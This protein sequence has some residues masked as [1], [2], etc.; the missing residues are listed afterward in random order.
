MNQT[1]PNAG[2]GRRNIR[3][4]HAHLAQHGRAMSM[5]RLESC[6]DLDDLHRR[7]RAAVARRAPGAGSWLLGVGLRIESWPEP[8]W[9]TA[10]ELDVSTG[11]CPT[12]LWSFDHHA[13]VVN[14]A[15]L[16]TLGI[17]RGTPDPDNGRIVRDAHSGHLTGLM[18]ERAAKMVWSRIPEPGKD[19]RRQQVRDALA[20]LAAHGFTEIHDLLS[21]P[22]LGPLL[23]ELDDAG[24]LPAR[25]VLYPLLPDFEAVVA[26]RMNWERDRLRLGGA[27]LFADG[28]L[29][30]R[31]AWMLSEYADPL[32]G[33]PHG[34]AMLSVAD[35][36]SAMERLW[37]EGLGLAVH[38]IGDGAVRAVLDAGEAAHIP[39]TLP[40]GLPPLRIEH[41]EIIDEADIPRFTAMGVVASVQPCHLL[42]DIEVLRR[43]LP[44]R[45]ERVLPLRDLIDSG[46]TPGEL[47]YFG[48]D[49]PIVR[50]HPADSIQAA[51]HRRREDMPMA[52]A[53]GA[54]QAIT[55]SESWRAFA[56]GEPGR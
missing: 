1:Q 37:P 29:N 55:E 56:G 18:L 35:L 11:G 32:P 21:Q 39:Q 34:Q 33:L 5:E 22:W 20:D 8:R 41:A 53:L 47:L 38:A 27:K 28:T 3:E 36:R 54:A 19:E 44:H 10:A 50:P 4:A 43:A 51:V 45:V 15:A 16:R 52:E 42:T 6:V 23:A 49:T 2:G 14:T 30:S 48:S 31:T 46:C 12:C 24:E 26:G 7:L 9:P 17:D 13:L 25:V 40:S